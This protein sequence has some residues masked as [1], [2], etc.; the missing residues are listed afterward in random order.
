MWA[1]PQELQS[2][3]ENLEAARILH[4]PVHVS[5][6]MEDD[7]LQRSTAY[8]S[9][10]MVRCGGMVETPLDTRQ[11][12]PLDGSLGCQGFQVPVNRTQADAGKFLL[13][14][15]ID[16]IRRRMRTRCTEIVQDH[17][18]L[19]GHAGNARVSHWLPPE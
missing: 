8:T 19:D 11:I 17:A 13:H 15:V 10:V 12:Q 4:E 6:S 16:F 5:G 1:Y 2:H 7:I 9:N 3:I 18:S 14:A